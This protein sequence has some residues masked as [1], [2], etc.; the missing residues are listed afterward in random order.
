MG[1]QRT[2]VLGASPEPSR[3]AHLAALRL[4]S[5]G[6]DVVLV[7]KRT[8]VIGDDPILPDIPPDVGVHTVTMYM[9]PRNQE[10]WHERILALA[11]QRIIFNPGAE[12]ADFAERARTAG[13]E[14]V[15]GC[16]LV[17]LATGQF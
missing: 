16:T 17:M 14:V 7:G 12:H 4:Q 5:Q 15:E 6:H 9:N 8:G 3:Y 2:L 13:I 1:P 10:V 11:P